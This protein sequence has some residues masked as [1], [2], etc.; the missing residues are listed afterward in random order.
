MDLV[1][2]GPGVRRDPSRMLRMVAI[3]GGT[4][5]ILAVAMYWFVGSQTLASAA[6]FSM[7]AAAPLRTP[8]LGTMYPVPSDA[9]LEAYFREMAR[10]FG[11]SGG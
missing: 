11:G 9:E 5:F 6:N 4:V 8:A 10:Y 3:A 7:P 1:I 2:G